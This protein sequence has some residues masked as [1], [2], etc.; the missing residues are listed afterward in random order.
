MLAAYIFITKI[1]PISI[2]NLIHPKVPAHQEEDIRD[3]DSGQVM[4]PRKPPWLRVV[5]SQAM[6]P[7]T[8]RTIKNFTGEKSRL[9]E[10]GLL[11]FALGMQMTSLLCEASWP[12]QMNSKKKLMN[13]MRQIKKGQ[14]LVLHLLVGE[15]GKQLAHATKVLERCLLMQGQSK[16]CYIARSFNIRRNKKIASIENYGSTEGV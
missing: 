1:T 7:P 4:Q 5:E 12:C 11:E 6:W 15:N 13:L 9:R 2:Q 14:K 3:W 16:V 8:S 10:E